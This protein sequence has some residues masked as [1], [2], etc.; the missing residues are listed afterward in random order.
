MMEE[1]NKA[2]SLCEQF[3]RFCAVKAKCPEYSFTPFA[4][5]RSSGTE[6]EKHRAEWSLC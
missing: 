5:K 1:K 2:D 6:K 3:L 4:E